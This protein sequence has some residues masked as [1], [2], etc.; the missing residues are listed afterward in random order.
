MERTTREL[1][2]AVK[3]HADQHYNSDGWDYISE[4]FDDDQ[5][6][7]ILTSPFD[8]ELERNVAVPVTAKQAIRLVGQVAKLHDDRRRRSN[9][10]R[11]DMQAEGE[12]W[13]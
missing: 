3:A 9:R 1:V 4:A 12:G 7:D 8:F 11:R 6:A 2:D 5:I 10:R 13:F